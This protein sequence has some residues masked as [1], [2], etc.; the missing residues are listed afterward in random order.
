M[1]RGK[2]MPVAKKC[3]NCDMTNEVGVARIK[4]GL[5]YRCR[6]SM[7]DAN[8]LNMLRQAPVRFKV[9][10]IILSTCCLLLAGYALYYS[11]IVLPYGGGRGKSRLLEFNGFGVTVPVLALILFAAGLLAVVAANYYHYA[12]DKTCESIIRRCLLTGL[13][14]YW[15][16]IFFS[17]KIN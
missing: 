4:S 14:L 12:N 13:F 9:T 8:T 11:H 17:D 6:K 1:P 5:C 3:R 16:S 10:L 2:V 15:I 7:H